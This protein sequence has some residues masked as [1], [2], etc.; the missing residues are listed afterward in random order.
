M[1]NLLPAVNLPSCNKV[2]YFANVLSRVSALSGEDTIHRTVLRKLTL[3]S[4][5]SLDGDA[6]G[7]LGGALSDSPLDAA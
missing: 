2:T 3:H 7:I 6:F 1:V 5:I 4:E